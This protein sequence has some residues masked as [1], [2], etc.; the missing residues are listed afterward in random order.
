MPE[1]ILFVVDADHQTGD[2][3]HRSPRGVTAAA[4]AGAIAIRSVDEYLGQD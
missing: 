2:V 1:P 4:A 3:R